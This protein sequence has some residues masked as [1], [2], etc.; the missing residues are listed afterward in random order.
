MDRTFGSV[1]KPPDDKFNKAVSAL[2]IFKAKLSQ[3]EG[4]KAR[5]K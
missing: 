3:I 5:S 2:H 1:S 4:H